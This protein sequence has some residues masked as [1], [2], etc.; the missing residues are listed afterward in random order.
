MLEAKTKLSKLVEAVE[1]GAESEIIIARNG[2]PAAKLV[3]LNATKKKRNL[4]L[5]A[6]KYPPMDFEAFQ[7]LD[8]EIEA[9]FLGD[10]K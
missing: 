10:D 4:G 2:K 7:A 3:P 5:L 8:A 6:G 1:S 9:M